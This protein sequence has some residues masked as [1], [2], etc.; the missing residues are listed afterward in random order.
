[1]ITLLPLTVVVPPLEPPEDEDVESDEE[2]DE[3]VTDGN[4]LLEVPDEPVL[5]ENSELLSVA[6][7]VLACE[8][9]DEVFCDIL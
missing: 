2:L 6:L 5:Y 8:V 3:L 9:P 4:R 7:E 1:M